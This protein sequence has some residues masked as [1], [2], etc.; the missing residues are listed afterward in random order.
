MQ[1]FNQGLRIK[2]AMTLILFVSAFK[3]APE[4]PLAIIGAYALI[5]ITHTIAVAWFSTREIKPI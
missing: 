4:Y 2:M 5:T 3:L 1:S